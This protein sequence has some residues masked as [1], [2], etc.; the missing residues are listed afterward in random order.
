MRH[1]ENKSRTSNL[2]WREYY[3]FGYSKELA[4]DLNFKLY[5]IPEKPAMIQYGEL[6]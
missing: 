3:L 6:V 4:E 1:P 2:R 5:K